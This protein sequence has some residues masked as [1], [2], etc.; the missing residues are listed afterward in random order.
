ML[1]SILKRICFHYNK[2][3]KN[4]SIS[5]ANGFNFKNN[6]F[7]FAKHVSKNTYFF[8]KCQK[9]NKNCKYS[10]F[11]Y[12]LTILQYSQKL[13]GLHSCLSNVVINYKKN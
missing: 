6:T 1:Y 3:I 7:Y 5:T 8:F 12:P 2:V 4:Y 9:H 13:K 10:K 11:T